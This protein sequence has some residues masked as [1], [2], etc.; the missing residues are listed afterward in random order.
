LKWNHVAK[1]DYSWRDEGLVH[2][3]FM[4]ARSKEMISPVKL[5]VGFK[6]TALGV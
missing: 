6:T 4:S 3:R 2:D 1:L 5:M